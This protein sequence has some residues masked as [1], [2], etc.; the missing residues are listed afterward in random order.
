MNQFC[1]NFQVSFLQ[2][3]G[4][5]INSKFI[6]KDCELSDNYYVYKMARRG[7]ADCVS[8]IHYCTGSPKG[9]CYGVDNY[10]EAFIGFRL[11][12]NQETLVGPAPYDVIW[13]QV[14]LFRKKKKNQ[15]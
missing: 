2:T 15:H 4:Y 12:L 11:Y 14:F 3:H 5:Y 13:D 8:I 9:A 7:R 10:Q 1:L 6:L